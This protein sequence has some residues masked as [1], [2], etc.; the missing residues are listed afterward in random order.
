MNKEDLK[1][2]ID[3]LR[4][5]IQRRNEAIEKLM[6]ARC[7]DIQ[8]ALRE[9]KHQADRKILELEKEIM[10]LAGEEEGVD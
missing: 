2:K 8:D 3:Q 1:R 7:G 5:Q 4:Y 9:E 10:K 6:D